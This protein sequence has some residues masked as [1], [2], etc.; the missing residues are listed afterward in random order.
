[1]K[2]NQDKCHFLSSLDIRTKF[3]L[4]V[5]LLENSHSQKLL[6]VAIDRKLDFNEHVTYLCYKATRKIQASQEFSHIYPEKKTTFNECLFGYCPLLW[7]NHSRT[8]NKRI[9][10][11]LK[12]ELSLVYKDFPLS[13]SEPLE[14]D[15]SVT[16]HHRNL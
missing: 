11:L 7:M 2:A 9:N 6:D 5:C 15:K 3:L 4:H 8:L 12:R 13:F 1:M 10:G 16:I 14:R